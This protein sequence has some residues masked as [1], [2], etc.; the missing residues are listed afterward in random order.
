M[1]LSLQGIALGVLFIGMIVLG[2]T[3]LLNEMSE[4]YDVPIDTSYE[5]TFNK[6]NETQELSLEVARNVKG[7]NFESVGGVLAIPKSGIGA[8]KLVMNGVGTITTMFTEVAIRIGIPAWLLASS[9]A[10][11]LLLVAFAL[12]AYWGYRKQ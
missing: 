11:L 8:M 3:T 9:V 1:T 10:M 5:D 6:L 2:T 12:L 4:N 7:S